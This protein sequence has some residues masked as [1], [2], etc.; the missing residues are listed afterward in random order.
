MTRIDLTN[1]S[2]SIARTVGLLDDA[3]SWLI[4]RDLSV[5]ISRFDQLHIDL[6]IS[7]KVLTRRLADLTD[8]GIIERTR[9]Q[10]NPPRHN[11]A[12]T[13]KGREL[14]PILVAMVQWGDRWE[15]TDAG[16]PMKFHHRGCPHGTIAACC[17]TCGEP[18][19]A[20]DIVASPGPG[21]RAGT[22]T[23]L[24]GDYLTRPE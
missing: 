17:R 16:P 18:L 1:V 21:G 10:D 20:A 14:L 15:P 12:L 13:D 7:R 6:G 19:A 9:Y 4:V 8:A 11:Y 23:A 5:G 3:W 22:G 2:C 24:I